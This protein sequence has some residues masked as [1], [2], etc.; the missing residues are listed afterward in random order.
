[1]RKTNLF[2]FGLALLV[3]A[4]LAGCFGPVP[5]QAAP[6][7][8]NPSFSPYK[9]DTTYLF[10]KVGHRFVIDKATPGFVYLS[11]DDN[12]VQVKIEDGMVVAYT[13]AIGRADVGIFDP[14]NIVHE[15]IFAVEE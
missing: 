8:E 3:L 9:D 10:G 13:K 15:F 6:F 14:A 7:D 12:I 11:D 5:V 2:G 4:S 1:M